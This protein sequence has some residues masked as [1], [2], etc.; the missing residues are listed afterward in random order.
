MAS[1]CTEAEVKLNHERIPDNDETD[2]SIA[3]NILYVSSLI[4]GF[5]RGKVQLPFTTIPVIVNGIAVDLVTYR[6]LRNLYGAQTEEFQTWVLEYKTP[7]MDI[8]EQIRDCKITL[9]P[10]DATPYSRVR[11]NTKDKEAIFDLSHPYDQ[12]Y[13]PTDGDDRYG[14]D[15]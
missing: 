4:D 12:D 8:L 2:A 14:E 9:D 10:D 7:A 11:S 13:H 3:M 1:Y 5:I 15:Q 6:T